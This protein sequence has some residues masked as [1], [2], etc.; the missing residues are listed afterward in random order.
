MNRLHAFPF[1]MQPTSLSLLNL[2]RNADNDAAWHQ[3]HELYAPMITNWLGRQDIA[4]A[5][6]EDLAQDVMVIVLRKLPQFDHNGR[7]GAFRKWLRMITINCS[8]DFWSAKRIRAKTT[9]STAFLQVL[10]QLSDDSS[11]LTR[12]WNQ[13]HD[14]AVMLGMMKQAKPSFDTKTWLAFQKTA[15]ENLPPQQVATQLKLSV[16]SVYTAKSRVLS[17]LRQLAA[18]L[19]D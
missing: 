19:I 5:E 8:R 11:E 2:A 12:K 4:G 17:R 10:E 16:S 18:E 13:E 7:Q 1:S 3:L 14:L 6:A 9:G 15:I